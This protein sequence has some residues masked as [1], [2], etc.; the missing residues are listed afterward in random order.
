MKYAIFGG[1]FNPVHNGHI[2]IVQKMLDYIKDLDH[3]YIVPAGCSPFKREMEDHAN[4][5]IRYTWCSRAFNRIDRTS[6]IDIERNYNPDSPSFTYDTIKLF[7]KRYQVFP[8]LIIGE[9]SLASFHKW[10]H[11]DKIL[12]KCQLAV[13]RRRG[14]SGKIKIENR[15]LGKIT[16]YDS[17]YIEISSTEIRKRINVN[18]SIRGYVPELLEDQIM[19]I[20]KKMSDG[21]EK[22]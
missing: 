16:V 2:I 1:S 7:Y 9:D 10:K 21:N 11:H 19:D 17:P 18:K 8:T 6:T 14:Y 3:L 15:Y 4:F 20:Y 12:E 13:F 5:D 22:S